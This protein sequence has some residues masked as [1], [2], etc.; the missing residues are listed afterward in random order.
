MIR[1]DFNLCAR[2][3]RQNDL[4]MA[5]KHRLSN[6]MMFLTV[7]RSKLL[8]PSKH[9]QLLSMFTKWE[10]L[11]V[12]CPK[13]SSTAKREEWDPSK[14]QK[15]RSAVLESQRPGRDKLASWASWAGAGSAAWC[16][17][18]REPN[19]GHNM[20]QHLMESIDC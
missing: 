16:D 6:Q 17:T 11:A 8:C 9:I 13:P 15:I 14:T 12:F 20:P 3:Q 18:P 2:N 19:D 1:M 7:E 5:V 10:D 4:D